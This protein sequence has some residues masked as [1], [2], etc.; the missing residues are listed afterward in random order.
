[1]Q[2]CPQ[3]SSST[4]RSAEPVRFKNTEKEFLP[5][6]TLKVEILKF[7]KTY[8]DRLNEQDVDYTELQNTYEDMLSELERK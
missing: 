7:L 6:E 4:N 8:L 3:E 1:L 5:T 2:V